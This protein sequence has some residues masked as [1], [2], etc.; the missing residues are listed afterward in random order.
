MLQ[1]IRHLLVTKI[2]ISAWR[3]LLLGW[4]ILIC[5]LLF[6]PLSIGGEPF[7]FAGEDKLVH[8]GMFGGW[9]F[10]LSMSLVSYEDGFLSQFITVVIVI[11]FAGGSEYTQQFI[12]GRGSDWIDFLV[13]LLGGMI[14]MGLA[15]SLKKGT[16]PYRK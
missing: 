16:N 8:L 12:P 1:R 13:D 4:S 7:L 11:A 10:L 5:I 6:L 2:K 3:W 14:G 15:F 9:S